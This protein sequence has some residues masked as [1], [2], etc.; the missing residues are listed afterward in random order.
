MR[1]LYLFAGDGTYVHQT[2]TTGQPATVTAFD[3]GFGYR[4][5]RYS[6]AGSTL[7]TTVLE[8]SEAA[9]PTTTPQTATDQ[10]ATR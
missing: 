8:A 5:G 10:P 7:T 3:A 2:I 1:E 6:L 9:G 4:Y